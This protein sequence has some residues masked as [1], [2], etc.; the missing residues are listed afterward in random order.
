[1]AG[2]SGNETEPFEWLFGSRQAK[3]AIIPTSSD[4]DRF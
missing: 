4:F 1:M 3:D 2:K